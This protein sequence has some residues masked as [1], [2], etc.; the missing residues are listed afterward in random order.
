M[1]EVHNFVVPEVHNFDVPAVHNF[2]V[3]EAHSFVV[4]AVHSFGACG[5]HLVPQPA[6]IDLRADVVQ[7]L[8]NF[9]EGYLVEQTRLPIP[10]ID[11]EVRSQV[12]E[13]RS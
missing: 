1:P 8:R 5:Q 4:P 6:K 2:D 3:P 9:P 13:G 11:S 12:Q 10:A 7:P